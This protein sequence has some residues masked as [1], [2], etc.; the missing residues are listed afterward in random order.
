M[1]EIELCHWLLLEPSGKCRSVF[2]P[3]GDACEGY[4]RIGQKASSTQFVLPMVFAVKDIAPKG[5]HIPGQIVLRFTLF[6]DDRSQPGPAFP[7][8]AQLK[9]ATLISELSCA[10]VQWISEVGGRFIALELLSDENSSL[11]LTFE[12]CVSEEY[13]MMRSVELTK[14][15]LEMMAFA[16]GLRVEFGV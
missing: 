1:N 9:V 2:A 5:A 15:G 10:V 4:S 16:R 7:G 11:R 12:P 14:A 6:R 8:V 3:G 13:K